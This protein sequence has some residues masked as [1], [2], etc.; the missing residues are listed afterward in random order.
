MA[1][2]QRVTGLIVLVV[3]ILGY[4]FALRAGVWP[5]GHPWSG[6]TLLS[7]AAFQLVEP[8]V[9]ADRLKRERAVLAR[10]AVFLTLVAAALWL[11]AVLVWPTA[12]D[13]I[14]SRRG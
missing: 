5:P 3:V 9:V 11:T 7:L 4:A 14:M 2:L 12:A 8:R 6:M 10:V 13:V 1:A